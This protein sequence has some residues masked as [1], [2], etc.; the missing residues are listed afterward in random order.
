MF[1]PKHH[2]MYWAS[3][4]KKK[5]ILRI[6]LIC[7]N[8]VI[9]IFKLDRRKLFKPLCTGLTQSNERHLSQNLKWMVK[10]YALNCLYSP[11]SPLYYLKI[12]FAWHLK[13]DIH[14]PDAT[15]VTWSFSCLTFQGRDAKQMQLKNLHH[16]LT[17]GSGFTRLICTVQA[18]SGGIDMNNSVHNTV[19]NFSLLPVYKT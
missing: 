9:F 7:Y 4:R 5:L 14:V 13:Y 18:I 15:Y 2:S 10:Y 17:E 16:S 3:V 19:R 1:C 8:R 11:L 12:C 6:N